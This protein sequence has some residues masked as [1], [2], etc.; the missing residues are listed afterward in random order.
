LD[1]AEASCKK[2]LEP[3][4]QEAAK[5]TL[6]NLNNSDLRRLQ[7][8][9]A[10]WDTMGWIYFR[11]GELALAESYVR[12]SWFEGQHREVGDHLGQIYEKQGKKQE[13]ANIYALA[14]AASKVSPDPAGREDMEKRLAALK[15]Q[16]IHSTYT[17]PG[18]ELGEQRSV[19]LPRL[20]KNYASADFFVVLAPG[21]VEETAFIRG[22]ESLKAAEEALRKANFEVPFP[23]DSQAKLIRRGILVCSEGSDKCQFTMLLPQSTT[24]D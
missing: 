1:I 4:D 24:T 7:L 2:A 9:A 16:G 15:A 18:R 22:D 20:S 12:A 21:K 13:A 6:N 23:K 11:K 14:V 5:L 10:A 3:L 8:L 19:Y 17:D